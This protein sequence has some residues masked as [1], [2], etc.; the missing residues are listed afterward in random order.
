MVIMAL[1]S[2]FPESL[3]IAT[4]GKEMVEV[5]PN[6]TSVASARS[7]AC[8]ST[9]KTNMDRVI[10]SIYCQNYCQR[11]ILVGSLTLQRRVVF[12]SLHSL[13]VAVLY[14][15]CKELAKRHSAK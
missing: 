13:C 5:V 1:V 7:K 6:L 4:A 15:H 2:L 3:Q 8:M 11:I 10:H 12:S 9:K 14:K